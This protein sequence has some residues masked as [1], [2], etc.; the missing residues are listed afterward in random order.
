MNHEQLEYIMIRWLLYAIIDNESLPNATDEA[1][2]P[3]FSDSTNSDSDYEQVTSL[4]YH[5]VC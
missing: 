3:L 5:T 2:G 1:D 4:I